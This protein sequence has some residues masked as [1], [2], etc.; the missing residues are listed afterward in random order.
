MHLPY[1]A[2]CKGKRDGKKRQVGFN[3]DKKLD[4]TFT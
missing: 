4:T 2:D 1:M 3:N